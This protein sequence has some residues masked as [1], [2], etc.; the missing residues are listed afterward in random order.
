MIFFFLNN[1]HPRTC[2]ERGRGRGGGGEGEGER[3]AED[4]RERRE[5]EGRGRK[6][7]GGEGRRERGE[8]PQLGYFGVLK[9]IITL[10]LIIFWLYWLVYMLNKIIFMV[11]GVRVGMI[12]V[13]LQ[14]F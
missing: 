6:G 14:V 5:R 9:Y 13:F 4:V 11:C 1:P 3:D 2:L 12:H 7:K 10:C 8:P